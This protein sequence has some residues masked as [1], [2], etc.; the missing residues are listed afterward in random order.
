MNN[1]VITN[2][3]IKRLLIS[4]NIFTAGRVFFEIFLNVYIWKQTGDLTLIAWFNI[5]YLL[6]HTIT[7][8]AFA[9]FVKKGK[10][11]L[12]RIIA[13][14][15]YTLT[16]L[17]IYLMKENAI[18]YVIPIAIVIGF[19][20][21]MYWISYQILRFDLTHSENRGNY[22]GLE[23][24]SKLFVGVVMPS[25]GG[26]IIAANFFGWGYSSLFLFGTVLFLVSLIIGNVKFPTYNTSKFHIRKTFSILIKDRDIMKSM[27][28]QF[29]S[30]FSRGGTIARLILPLLIFDIM[31]NELGLGV[32]L[33]FFSVVA[34]VNSFAFGKLIKY[35]YYKKL[36]FSGGV[37]YFFLIVLLILF[38]SFW[39]YILFGALIKI[40]EAS[41][42][43]PKRVISE[44][45][46][47]YL[48]DENNHRIEYIVIREWFNIGFG[49][50]GSFVLLLTVGELAVGQM[51]ALLFLMAIAVLFEVFLIKSI[52]KSVTLLS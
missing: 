29:F 27:F 17:V 28:A 23:N 19:F 38:P 13:L 31:K 41:I 9:G 25:L 42:N 51:K 34:I 32:W 26:A 24:G 10:V 22:T 30:S 1:H 44:N 20:N 33:S 40:V 43:I 6:L 45:L 35:K 18:N 15:G 21:G 16:Y 4:H 39:I 46:V 36:L 14:V 50:I 3:G 48:E 11:H 12:P 5:A 8:H 47:H 7:F 52:K 37:V 49:R 2:T